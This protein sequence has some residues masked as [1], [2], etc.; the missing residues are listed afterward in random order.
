MEHISSHMM[1]PKCPQIPCEEAVVIATGQR[2]CDPHRSRP[3]GRRLGIGK[4]WSPTQGVTP[5]G[6]KVLP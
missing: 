3:V 5:S 1:I 4:E 6:E 2:P